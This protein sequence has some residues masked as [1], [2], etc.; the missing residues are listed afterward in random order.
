MNN[1]EISIRLSLIREGDKTAFE[2]LY[3]NLK[4]PVYT[5]IHRVTWD[6]PMSEDIL[7][8]VFF[9]LWSAPPA[10]SIENPRAYIFRMARNSAIDSTRKQKLNL[11][12]DDIEVAVPDTA[13]ELSLK[14]DISGA[15]KTLPD[16]E[17][18]IVTLHLTGELK[19]REISEIMK[20]PLGTV[21][22]RYQKAIGKLRKALGG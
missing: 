9:K 2:E 19:F 6:T 20:I 11:S 5:I 4:T 14:M 7:Q 16:E 21:L 3:N 8:E 22:W 13:E 10:P 1:N 17:C 18:Q 12:L 15:L